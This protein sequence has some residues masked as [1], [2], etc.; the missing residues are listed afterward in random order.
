MLSQSELPV[1]VNVQVDENYVKKLTS[2]KV[3]E[4]FEKYLRP[5]WYT[6]ADMEKITRHKRAWIMQYIVEDPYV[7]KNKLAKK[8]GDSKN[9]AWLFDAEGI[10]P[11]LKRLFS[12]LP[13]C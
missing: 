5:E 9:A 1:V 7:R 8:D 10:R 12:E 13:G 2:E 3:D 4:L 6:M 11:F